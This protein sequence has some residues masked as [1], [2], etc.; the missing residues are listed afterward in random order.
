MSERTAV[1]SVTAARIALGVLAV[2]A[3]VV[4]ALCMHLDTAGAYGVPPGYYESTPY[5]EAG[6]PAEPVIVWSEDFDGAFHCE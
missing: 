4:V 5:P 6:A 1:L 2:L 3:A